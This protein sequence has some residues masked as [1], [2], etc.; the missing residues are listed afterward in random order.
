[1]TQLRLATGQWQARNQWRVK[2]RRQLLP[3]RYATLTDL[4]DDLSGD[5]TGHD[6]SVQAPNGSTMS[7]SAAV[8]L[9]VGHR[10]VQA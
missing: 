6:W 7:L 5:A 10:E 4:V 1:M 9:Y 8:C 3:V 2:Y